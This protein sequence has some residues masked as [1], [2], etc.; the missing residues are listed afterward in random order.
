MFRLP[1]GSS[2]ISWK[3]GA[4]LIPA[5]MGPSL[6]SVAEK[7]LAYLH[8][9]L[10]SLVQSSQYCKGENHRHFEGGVKLGVGAFNL[11]SGNAPARCLC[12]PTV[13]GP[14]LTPEPRDKA[15]TLPMSWGAQSWG[16][17]GWGCPRGQGL[18]AHFFPSQVE[19]LKCTIVAVFIG[20]EKDKHNKSGPF[21]PWR[22]GG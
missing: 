19:R 11:V 13:L 8:R 16:G 4:T 3:W 5:G 20:P 22:S 18:S 12:W 14:E 21:P 6:H 7:G 1:P 17:H 2:E 10:D 9:E 15:D